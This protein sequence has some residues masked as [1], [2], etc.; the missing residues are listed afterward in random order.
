MRTC[1]HYLGVAAHD[2]HHVA[3]EYQEFA[4]DR[5]RDSLRDALASAKALASELARDVDHALA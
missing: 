1:A 5:H 2:L 4:D 3:I